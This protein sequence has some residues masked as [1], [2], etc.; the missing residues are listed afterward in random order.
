MISEKLQNAINEQITA[1]MWSSN[2]YLAMSFYFEKEGF[3]GFAALTALTSSTDPKRCSIP[4]DKERSGF[5]M[6]EG[7]GVVVLEELEHAYTMADYV[8]KRGGKAKIDKIDVVP[9][10][11]GS[12]LEVFQHVYEHECKVSKMIDNLVSIA[13][14]EKDNATQDFLWGFVR[15]QVEEEATAQGIVDKLKKAGDTGLLFIDAQL[16][17]R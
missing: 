17:K 4:F 11:W 9:Q 2:L 14:A 7:A 6:G 1:E 16:A 12:P 10:G 3:S 15:E 13:S 8:T 5:V